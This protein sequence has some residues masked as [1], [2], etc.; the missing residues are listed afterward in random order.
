M[1][2]VSERVEPRPIVYDGEI[3]RLALRRTRGANVVE[4]RFVYI[5]AIL[6]NGE[7]RR[8][9][10]DADNYLPASNSSTDSLIVLHGGEVKIS[11]P[12]G[13][14]TYV[15][16]TTKE[17]IDADAIAGDAV[18]SRGESGDVSPLARLLGDFGNTTRGMRVTSAADWSLQ[19]LSILSAPA[20]PA[21]R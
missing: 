12:F 6:C 9:W 15:L 2:P 7:I 16:L 17:P 4:R 21:R 1:D 20:A 8:L 14:D 18:V 3:F 11:E 10:G 19:R 5:F 13:V